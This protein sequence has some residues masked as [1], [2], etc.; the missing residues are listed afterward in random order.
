[1]LRTW[2]KQCIDLALDKYCDNKFHFLA[3]AT[4]GAGKTFMAANLA[5]R[6]FDNRNAHS[7]QSRTVLSGLAVFYLHFLVG[8]VAA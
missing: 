7:S 4:P 8:L 2:Q 5:K 3:Q 1:M 6:M